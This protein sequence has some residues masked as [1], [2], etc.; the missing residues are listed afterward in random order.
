VR[1]FQSARLDHHLR[2]STHPPRSRE[3]RRRHVPD[4][5]RDPLRARRDRCR[6]RNVAR[7]RP[8]RRRP[9]ARHCRATRDPL[10]PDRRTVHQRHRVVTPRGRT[11]Q[12][13]PRRMAPPLA[14]V[15]ALERASASLALESVLASRSTSPQLTVVSICRSTR[16]SHDEG[17]TIGD[18]G[19]LTAGP[20]R[21]ARAHALLRRARRR[22]RQDPQADL[23]LGL[24]CNA[25][26]HAVERPMCER[27]T[28]A[29]RLRRPARAPPD[30]SPPSAADSH[31]SKGRP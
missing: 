6:A 21:T 2:S 7:H 12:A 18:P 14:V 22:V 24:C 4:R 23:R 17:V 29:G 5:P 10:D 15:A 31:G 1:R 26:T 25:T 30:L 28:R 11:P 3:L 9:T 13:L 19:G 27:T 8:D 20:C 16:R